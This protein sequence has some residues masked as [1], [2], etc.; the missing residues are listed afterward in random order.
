MV[1]N[2]VGNLA[3][4]HIFTRCTHQAI[5]ILDD[6]EALVNAGP[7]TLE[8]A[9]LGLLLLLPVLPPVTPRLSRGLL[10]PGRPAA[11]VLQH[12]VAAALLLQ[13][14]DIAAVLAD[15][16]AAEVVRDVELVG[17]QLRV[18]DALLHTRPGV[19]ERV[20]CRLKV[21]NYL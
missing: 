21:N 11:A 12:D 20:T 5:L 9:Q 6:V 17:H 14:L 2:N 15:E 4:F 10:G 19:A 8:A 18:L 3:S 1:S 16:L 7:G 13:L